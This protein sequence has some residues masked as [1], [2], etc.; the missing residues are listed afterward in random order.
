[1]HVTLIKA[2]CVAVNETKKVA[3]VAHKILISLSKKY[4]VL[5]F[6]CE[7]FVTTVVENDNM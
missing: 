4:Q 1:M 3:M 6:W 5:T 2:W 7:V